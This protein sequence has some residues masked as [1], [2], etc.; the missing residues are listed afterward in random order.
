MVRGS[1]EQALGSVVR[2]AV[3]LSAELI[4]LRVIRADAA[5]KGAS[6]Y[7]RRLSVELE[8]VLPD[9]RATSRVMSGSPAATIRQAT[10]DV[11]MD[12]IAMARADAAVWFVPCAVYG[13]YSSGA[14]PGTSAASGTASTSPVR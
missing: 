2:L 11:D 9:G 1:P 8:S 13:D 12:A 14:I 7:L 10:L 4:L 3:L 5:V 6:E